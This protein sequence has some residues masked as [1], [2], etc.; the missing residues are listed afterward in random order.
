M[1][2]VPEWFHRVED[3]LMYSFFLLHIIKTLFL[4]L[5]RSFV[6]RR[7]DDS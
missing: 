3:I 7:R 4:P 1:S 5:L 6:P 2:S